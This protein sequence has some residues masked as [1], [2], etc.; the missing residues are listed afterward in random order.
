MKDISLELDILKELFNISVGKASSLL[1]E[2][3]ERKIVLNI[4]DV[5]LINLENKKNNEEECP[6]EKS[7]SIFMIS[8][9]S[10][11]QELQGKASLIFSAEKM[12]KFIDLCQKNDETEEY[13]EMDFSD[14]DLDVIK[15]IGNI[16]LNSVV[17]EVGNILDIKLIYTLPEVQVFKGADFLKDM[18][19]QYTHVLIL[20]ITFL[21]E[22]TKI[23][24]AILVNLTFNSFTD[25]MKKIEKIGDE[26]NE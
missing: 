20:N 19:C 5:K 2:I 22:N 10:F 7:D 21:I 14:I 6:P 24:G 13:S 25:I 11:E 1:S 18:D 3:T 4:P 12:R 8:S 26:L 23:E 9:I 17:G 16:V 15:E